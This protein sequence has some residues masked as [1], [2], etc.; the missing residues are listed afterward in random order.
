[1]TGSKHE[2]FS[3]ERRQFQED[4]IHNFTIREDQLR[5]KTSNMHVALGWLR[6]WRFET[7]FHAPNK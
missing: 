2:T 5:I 6:V 4:F 7:T 3:K 1:M